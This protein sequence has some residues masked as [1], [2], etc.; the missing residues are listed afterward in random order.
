MDLG[1]YISSQNNSP[2]KEKRLSVF[3]L[4]LGLSPLRRQRANT[5]GN[6]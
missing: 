3:K 5:V 1:G 2:V 6:F 4:N